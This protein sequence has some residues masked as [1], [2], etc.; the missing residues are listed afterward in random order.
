MS[1]ATVT[2]IRLDNRKRANLASAAQAEFYT[3]TTEPSG[4]II[5]DPAV[6]VPRIVEDFRNNSEAL[7]DLAAYR[8]N[9]DDLVSE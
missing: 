2:T 3:M 1:N 4:R 8:A 7:A 9:P 5:L 6:V